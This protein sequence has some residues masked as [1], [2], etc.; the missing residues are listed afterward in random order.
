MP[1]M[2]LLDLPSRQAYAANYS[3][4]ARI[5]RL[6]FAAEKNVGKPLE[7]EALKLAADALKK[8]RSSC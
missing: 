8:V 2:L 1:T 4:H 3:G 7:L 5:D 6:L